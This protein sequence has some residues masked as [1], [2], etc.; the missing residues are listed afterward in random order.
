VD[1][2]DRSHESGGQNFLTKPEA[3]GKNGLNQPDL[4]PHLSKNLF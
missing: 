3:A 2:I 1:A 4:D